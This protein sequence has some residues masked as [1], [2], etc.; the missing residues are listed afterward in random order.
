MNYQKVY[1]LIVSL[2]DVII[3]PKSLECKHFLQICQ[4]IAKIVYEAPL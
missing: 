2:M 1:F 3:F 4:N